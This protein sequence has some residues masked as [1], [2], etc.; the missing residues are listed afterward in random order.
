MQSHFYIKPSSPD[1]CPIDQVYPIRGS[2]DHYV[3]VFLEPIKLSQQLVYSRSSFSWK[4]HPFAPAS[5]CVQLIDKNDATLFT[6]LGHLEYLSDLFGTYS[7]V[8]LLELGCAGL[9]KGQVRLVGQ[10]LGQH[11]LACPWRSVQQ[12]ALS[13]SSAQFLEFIFVIQV[14]HK[15]L[16]LELDFLRAIEILKVLVIVD[17]FGTFVDFAELSWQHEFQC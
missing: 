14:F 3:L 2:N 17:D 8:Y 1:Q 16:Q 9:N 7:Y 10:G 13:N 11:R 5:N 15:F 12:N 4:S 6:A